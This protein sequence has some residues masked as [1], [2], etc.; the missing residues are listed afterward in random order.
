LVA[1]ETGTAERTLALVRRL[2]ERGYLV[3]P[4]GSDASALQLAPPFF[5]KPAQID[6]LVD[7]LEECLGAT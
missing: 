5:V 4:A 3:L 7:A 1:L 6:G 2:L